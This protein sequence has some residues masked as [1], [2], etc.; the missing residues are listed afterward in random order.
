MIQMDVNMGATQKYDTETSESV[1]N[2][3]AMISMEIF[4]LD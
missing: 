3:K 1:K 4:E 2:S